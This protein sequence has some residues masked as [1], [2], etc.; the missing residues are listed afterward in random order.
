MATFPTT[1]K[2]PSIDPNLVAEEWI[3]SFNKAIKNPQTELSS[4]FLE[5]SYWRDQLCLSWDFHTLAGPD[6]ILGIIQKAKGCRIQSITLDKSS[7][8]RLPSVSP[9]D[10]AGTVEFVGA[11]LTVETDVGSGE[12]LVRLVCDQ[13]I[14]K[15]FTLFTTLQKLHSSS[16]AVGKQRPH[17][18]H[19][20]RYTSDENWLD[21]RISELKCE[22]EDEPTVLIVGAYT[23]LGLDILLSL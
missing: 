8:V 3:Q 10:A 16:E 2:L 14:W 13:G 6:K 12:G 7:T 19:D 20:E 18:A 4:L 9:L 21:R 1:T 15:V 23:L 11:F 22:G 5:E 17:G